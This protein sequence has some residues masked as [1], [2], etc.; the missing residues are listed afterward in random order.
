MEFRAI[1]EDDFDAFELAL[2]NAF[3]EVEAAKDDV[4]RD[5]LCMEFDRTFAAFDDGRIVGC[6]GAFT[7]ESVTP[8]EGR[9]GTA[10]VTM[11][12]VLPTH[13]RRGILTELMARLLR[14]AAERGEPMATLLASEGQI[15]GRFGYGLAEIGQNYDIALERVRWAPRTLP[16]GRTRLLPPAEARPLMRAVYERFAS[17]RPAAVWPTDRQFEWIFSDIAK[18][19]E[20]EFFVVHE[21]EHGLPDA[22]AIYR[23]KHEWPRGLPSLELKVRAFVA[24]TPEA[25]ASMWRYLFDIDLVSRIKAYARPLDDPLTWQMA[26]PRALRAELDDMLYARPVDVATALAARGFAADGRLRIDV[27]DEFW[28]KNTGTYELRVEEGSATCERTSADADVACSVHAIGSTY[29]G[30]ASW[31][32]LA[33]AGRVEERTEG[34]IGRADAMFAT[35]VSPWRMIEF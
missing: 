11:V 17:W 7:F 19:D 31:G 20:K 6:A 22:Y 15:Y 26:E 23:I 33:R 35:A 29:F 2:S 24:C 18:D 9:V 21:D 10:G 1:N 28:P 16:V 12:G 5:R 4:E 14:Q 30:G 32:T 34:S 25:S 27:H 3:G 13:R 8:G